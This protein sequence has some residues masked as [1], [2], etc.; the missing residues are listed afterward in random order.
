VVTVNLDPHLFEGTPLASGDLQRL[1]ARAQSA[2]RWRA[3]VDALTGEADEDGVAVTVTGSGAISRLTVTDAACANGG[4]ALSRLV[5]A[6]VRLAHEDLAGRI[7]S[8]SLATFG[9]DS[10]E[11]ATVADGTQRRFGRSAV[12]LETDFGDSVSWGDGRDRR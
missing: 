1:M 3:T 8:S 6:A 10:D 4:E 12:V 2:M 9:E 11:A 7:R 5:I